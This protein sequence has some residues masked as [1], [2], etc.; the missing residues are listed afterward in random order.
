MDEIMKVNNINGTTDKTCK[1]GVGL[2]IAKTLVSNH[3]RLIAQKKAVIISQ[4]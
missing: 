2:I 3:F 4:K 1:C